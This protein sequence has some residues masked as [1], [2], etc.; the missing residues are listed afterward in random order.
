MKDDGK[1]KPI[2]QI[3]EEEKKK[4]EEEKPKGLRNMRLMDNDM[5]ALKDKRE[6]KVMLQEELKESN[7]R[8]KAVRQGHYLSDV[9]A[10]FA[11]EF[12]LPKKEIYTVKGPK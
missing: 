2:V 6:A 1:K 12:Y 11:D 3:S 5:V 9:V 10:P 8:L 7:L 4:D